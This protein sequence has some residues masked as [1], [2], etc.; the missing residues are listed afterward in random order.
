MRKGSIFLSIRLRKYPFLRFLSNLLR[1]CWLFFP[2]ILFIL[3]AM[4][5]FSQMNQGKDILISFTETTGSFGH[6]LAA[7]FIFLIAIFFWVYVSW[8]SSRMVGY[9]KHYQHREAV[10]IIDPVL[11]DA[12]YE[13]LYDMELRFLHRFPRIIG[14]SC[15]ISVI[16]VLS[17]LLF[18]ESRFDQLPLLLLFA[19]SFLTWLADRKMIAWSALPGRSAL[20]R[21]LAWILFAVILLLTA[22]FV[23][24]DLFRKLPSILLLLFLLLTLYML[25]VN[26]RRQHMNKMEREA[27]RSTQINPVKPWEKLIEAGM[28]YLHLPKEEKNYFAVFNLICLLGLFFYILAIKSLSASVQ[29]GPF[30][31]L[32]LAFAV[33][34]G[35]GGLLSALSCKYQVN[36]HF[37]IFLL[38]AF[39]PTPDHHLVR[40][41]SLS[42]RSVDPAIYSKRQH[43][44][45]YYSNWLRD[46]NEIDSSDSYDLYL[47]L[48]NG[49][50]SRSAYWVASVLGKLEDASLQDPRGRFSRHLF[51][52]SGTSGGAF[53]IS[54]FYTTLLHQQE[55]EPVKGFEESGRSFLRQDFLS[56]TLA[57]MLGPDFFN[58]IP[59]LNQIVPN[60]DRAE[61][62]EQA[63]E[64]G[65]DNAYYR[66]GFDSTW[67]DQCLTQSGKTHAL[68]ILFINT[69]RVKDGS[70]GVVSNIHVSS[71]IFNQR[72]DV[73]ALL[74]EDR[75]IRL[76][77]A[78]I[79][80]AR[81]PYISP[82]GRINQ[83]KKPSTPNGSDSI[84]AHY[85]VDGGYFDNS[86]AGAVQEMIRTLLFFANNSKD[87][88]LR[89]RAAKLNIRVVHI[90]NSPQGTVPLKPIGPFV[91]DL[92]APVMTI[93]GAFDMQT[94]VNDR[95]FITY[96]QD[97]Q[98]IPGAGPFRSFDYLPIHL[99]NDPAF[100]GD[101]LSRG[102]YAMNWF[103]SDSVRNQM[104]RRLINQ[105]RLQLLVQ[106]FSHRAK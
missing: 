84:R 41:A 19:G 70:P 51:C 74:P 14:Y 85:F 86:G 78:T 48:A 92:L 30:A 20:L 69:T 106:E 17:L 94:T 87:A 34:L 43:L 80:G 102:P 36:V 38:A 6:V 2:S 54:N 93:T 11:S 15:L 65:K 91:N 10:R 90:T 79:L 73:A 49:G 77:T 5:V 81:F 89:R 96:I 42:D 24:Q 13:K 39:L 4:L 100:P 71:N 99:Y 23:Q 104:D 68:P 21:N 7:K 97:L 31:V 46:R 18:P 44:S 61:A 3:L 45:E 59:L 101:T 76:S 88:V 9:I 58:Y 103:I 82:A 56:F 98:S 37:F 25:Y 105:P 47:V 8:Y 53:G 60:E 12:G 64:Q 66:V 40:T 27:R 52:L 75:S 32:L 72:V 22:F 35:F 26:V 67:F 1:S 63:I 62:L 55:K 57:R 50:A 33:L 29:M 83:L 16:I 28:K 95:R